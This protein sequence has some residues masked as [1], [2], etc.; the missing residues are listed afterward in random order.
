MN[1][2]ILILTVLYSSYGKGGVSVD[3]LE[4]NDVSNCNRIGSEWVSNMKSKSRNINVS[5]MC[6][7]NELNK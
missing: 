2:Y 4:V 7:K 6:I 5:F 1:T 3:S